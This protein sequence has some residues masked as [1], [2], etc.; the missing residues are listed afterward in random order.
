MKLSGIGVAG[1]LLIV[2]VGLT[3]AQGPTGV[4]DQPPP[5]P[6]GSWAGECAIRVFDDAGYDGDGGTAAFFGS[7]RNFAGLYF[8]PTLKVGPHQIN[9]R[10]SSFYVKSGVWY[11]CLDSEYRSCYG[12]YGP[13]DHEENLV[14]V[15]WF[16]DSM[17]SISLSRCDDSV[18]ATTSC[19]IF[20]CRHGDEVYKG[21]L[22]KI[23][24]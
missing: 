21:D 8:P 16:Q 2:G 24:F 20:G 5:L 19:G 15:Q 6:N 13:G 9:D 17:S 10:V 22:I 4:G 11:I 14:N 1:L 7:V 3:R 23:P 12:P 18:G